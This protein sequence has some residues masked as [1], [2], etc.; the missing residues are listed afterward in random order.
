[1]IK[2]KCDTCGVEF[3]CNGDRDCKPLIK[4]AKMHNHLPTCF[5]A[6]CTTEGHLE[7]R[8]NLPNSI[9]ECGYRTVES[10][11]ANLKEKVEFQ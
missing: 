1:L 7:S 5:C 8:E 6:K 3:Y 2:A 4:H 11:E 9:R 10:V